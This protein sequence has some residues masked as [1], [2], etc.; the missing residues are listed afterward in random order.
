METSEKIK[1]ARLKYLLEKIS[2][3]FIAEAPPAAVDRFFY[4]EC[5]EKHDW[6]FLGIQKVF[7]PEKADI[8]LNS[9]RPPFL[10]KQMLENFKRK[11]RFLLDLYPTAE[12]IKGLSLYVGNCI[13]TIE[14]YVAEGRMS[15]DTPIILIKSTV[16]DS[17]Y[18][19]LRNK[20]YNVIDERIPFPSSGQQ[21]RFAESFRRA[22]KKCQS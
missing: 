14:Q 20:G 4:Y 19:P 10:K 8:Y 2:M 12:I 15:K 11:G 9:H 21:K 5:V 6:L 17:L 13:G 1:N 16:Y 22:L 18:Y 3:L 7:E